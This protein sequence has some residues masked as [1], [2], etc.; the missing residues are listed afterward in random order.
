MTG[1]QLKSL[2]ANIPGNA[3]VE[4]ISEDRF[5]VDTCYCTGGALFKSSDPGTLSYL[6]VGLGDGDRD[7]ILARYSE[8]STPKLIAFVSP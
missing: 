5:G 6:L 7:E 1:A 2:V 3:T 8:S 4:I